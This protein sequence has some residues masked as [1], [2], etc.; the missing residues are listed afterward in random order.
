MKELPKN[1]SV[2]IDKIEEISKKL[3]IKI[4]FSRNNVQRYIK[5]NINKVSGSLLKGI[6]KGVIGTFTSIVN[7]LI[8][9][10][11]LFLIPVFFFYVINDFEQIINE[12]KSYIPDFILPK[13]THYIH[14]INDVLHGY[15]RGQLM[16]ALILAGLYAT[17]LSIVGLKFGI[18]I[19]II[20]GLISVIPYAGFTLGFLAAIVTGLANNTGL[21]PIFG[22]VTVFTIVQLLEGF[23]ITPKL[24]G[25][26][27]G[28]SSFATMLALIIGGN[29]LG[30]FGMLIAIP[31]AAILKSIVIDL[32]EEF[33][34]FQLSA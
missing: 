7:W 25:N 24:V 6:S 29:L 23:V 10:L 33:H 1:T 22:I 16:V 15:I 14:L 21:G 32:K 3:G 34:S 19:G 18:L 11:N 4:D 13:L 17:G 8:A 5:N 2:A 26:K 28:L 31:A 12:I 30:L 27:V 20:S 9:I